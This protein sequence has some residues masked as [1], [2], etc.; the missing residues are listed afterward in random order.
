[1]QG[2]QGFVKE[3]EKVEVASRM[4]EWDNHAAGQDSDLRCWA[5]L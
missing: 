2:L 1:M 3:Q 5:K 4:A